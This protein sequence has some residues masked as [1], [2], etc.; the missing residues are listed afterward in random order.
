MQAQKFDPKKPHGL[1]YGS[2]D[3]QYEQDGVLYAGDGQVVSEPGQEIKPKQAPKAT[4]V[5]DTKP[6]APK[7]L[8]Q[9]SKSAGSVAEFLTNLLLGGPVLQVNIK[10]EAESANQPWADVQSMCAE[11]NIEK[12][13]KGTLVMWKLPEG[14]A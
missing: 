12:I 3:A 1:I 2:A 7:S 14:A 5:A 9:A 10:R 6:E 11:M 13:K 4:K 8:E